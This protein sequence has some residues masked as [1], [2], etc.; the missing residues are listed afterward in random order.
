MADFLDWVPLHVPTVKC[1]KIDTSLQADLD[2]NSSPITAGI[3]GTKGSATSEE[4]LVNADVAGAVKGALR[5]FMK[6]LL[7]E[8]SKGICANLSHTASITGLLSL[9]IPLF[10]AIA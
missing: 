1:V 10:P 7:L 8:L 5:S 2:T 9:Q 3:G 4:L 6:R